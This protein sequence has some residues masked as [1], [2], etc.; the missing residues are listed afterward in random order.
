MVVKVVFQLFFNFPNHGNK[1]ASP[2]ALQSAYSNALFFA[3]IDLLTQF[4]L[5]TICTQSE[6][7]GIQI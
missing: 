1:E 5:Q 3:K 4:S 2:K 6:F 7:L